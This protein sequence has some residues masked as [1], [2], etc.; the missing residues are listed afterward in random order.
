MEERQERVEEK[1]QGHKIY[2]PISPIVKKEIDLEGEG[3]KEEEEEEEKRE[4][5]RKEGE[6]SK[7]EGEVSLLEGEKRLGKEAT[8]SSSIELDLHYGIFHDPQEDALVHRGESLH[9]HGGYL[10]IT[11]RFA[12]NGSHTKYCIHDTIY[13]ASTV[14][15]ISSFASEFNSFILCRRHVLQHDQGI[16]GKC[17]REEIWARSDRDKISEDT[18]RECER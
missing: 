6:V 12:Y 3:T 18:D 13:M 17:L 9:P 8:T 2:V 14:S 16:G 15:C 1:M 11:R 10:G 5:S 7:E 4:R